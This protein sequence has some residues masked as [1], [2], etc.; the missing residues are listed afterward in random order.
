MTLSDFSLNGKIALV[1]GAFQV[2][3]LWH[4]FFYIKNIQSKHFSNTLR[5]AHRIIDP[6]LSC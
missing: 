3:M 4:E 5:E 6:M 1:T 2:V